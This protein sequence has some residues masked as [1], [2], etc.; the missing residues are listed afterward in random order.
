MNCI[1]FYNNETVLRYLL[2]KLEHNFVCKISP[3]GM[4]LQLFNNQ[5]E[6]C[7]TNSTVN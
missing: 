2:F 3:E 5:D 7:N 6:N 1:F 4:V